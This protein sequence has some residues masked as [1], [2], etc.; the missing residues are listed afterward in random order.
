MLRLCGLIKSKEYKV[1]KQANTHTKVNKTVHKTMNVFSKL[2]IVCTS[3]LE[4]I[5]RVVTYTT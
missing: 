1:T 5:K 2:D 4:L 3:V